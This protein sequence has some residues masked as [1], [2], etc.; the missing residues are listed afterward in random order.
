MTQ[1][2][3][4]KP[5]AAR[6]VCIVEEHTF[7]RRR[8]LLVGIHISKVLHERDSLST[9]ALVFSLR[10]GEAARVLRLVGF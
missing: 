10:A 1:G 5:A 7:D 4:G 3:G 2:F 9:G 6:T 8:M